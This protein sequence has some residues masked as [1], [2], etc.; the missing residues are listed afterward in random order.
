M[1]NAESVSVAAGASVAF[2]GDLRM[3]SGGTLAF[4]IGEDGVAGRLSVSGTMSFA[5]PQTVTVT[6]QAK[7]LDPGNYILAEAMDICAPDIAGWTVTFWG[8][9]ADVAD[10]IVRNSQIVM[11]I[12]GGLVLIVK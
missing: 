5:G 7:K 8:P 12:R 9:Q 1:E 6:S 4:G 2:E 11:R 3:A 10:L